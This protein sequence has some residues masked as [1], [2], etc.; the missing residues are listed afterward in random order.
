MTHSLNLSLPLVGTIS[1]TFLVAHV[2]KKTTTCGDILNAKLSCTSK[3]SQHRRLP[4][5][6]LQ[7]VIKDNYCIFSTRLFHMC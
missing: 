5:Y 2:Y 3:E 7:Q 4:A 6:R 1:V